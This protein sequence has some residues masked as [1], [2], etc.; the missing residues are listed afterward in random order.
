MT[1]N[2]P[3]AGRH[4]VN[5]ATT[6]AAAGDDT[7]TAA[8]TP[9]R[10]SPNA[11]LWASAFVLLGLITL[12]AGRFSPSQARAELV[13]RAGFLTAMTVDIGNSE[14]ALMVLDHQAEELLIYKVE[15]QSRV[16]FLRKYTLPKV[17]S[18]ARAKALGQK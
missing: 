18:E 9:R 16:E 17:F 14:S 2:A 10:L 6:A 3:E 12:Q 7:R 8:G 15:A 5:G 4:E 11:W 13:S 1:S